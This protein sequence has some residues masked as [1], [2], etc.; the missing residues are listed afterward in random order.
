MSIEIFYIFLQ[1][2]ILIHMN[3]KYFFIGFCLFLFVIQAVKAQT[4]EPTISFYSS[5]DALVTLGVGESQNCQAPLEITFNANL[6]D[7]SG[8]SSKVEWRLYDE[9]EGVDNPILS[10]FEENSKYTLDKYGAYGIVLYVT[11]TDNQGNTIDY[12]SQPIHISISESKL[13]CPNGFSPN[14]DKINDIFE[15]T[16]QSIV[17]LEG[18]IFNRWGQKLHTFNLGN[19]DQG[20]DGYYN[21]KV[22]KDGAYFLNIQAVGSD[23]VKYDIKKVINVLTGFRT[24]EK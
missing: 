3:R 5:D 18:G 20:W 15:I 19:V 7:N 23:G 24:Y 6:K 8:Y 16:Y 12:E 2:N 11:F 10:R 17:K 13:S 1:D 22:V 9:K 14:D 4:A 21:G